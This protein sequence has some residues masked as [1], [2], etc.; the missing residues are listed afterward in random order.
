MYLHGEFSPR[1]GS[2]ADPEKNLTFRWVNVPSEEQRL[3][4]RERIPHLSPGLLDCLLSGRGHLPWTLRAAPYTHS[5][6]LLA[7]CAW[8]STV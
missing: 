3:A 1:A 7:C 4:P 5:P 2:L 8:P 6:A